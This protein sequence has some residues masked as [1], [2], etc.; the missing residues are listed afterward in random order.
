MI[1]EVFP[2][3][4]ARDAECQWSDPDLFFPEIMTRQVEAT[5]KS[6]CNVHCPVQSECLEFA[7]EMESSLSV[8]YRAGIWVGSRLKSVA[9]LTGSGLGSKP[10]ALGDIPDPLAGLVGGAA[11]HAQGDS[12][13]PVSSR[14]IDGGDGDACVLQ[15]RGV[16]VA[17]GVG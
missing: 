16:G 15:Q 10:S 4:W 8:R 13:G 12:W 9:I 2:G 5:A 17:Q 14:L 11:V 1:G 3:E 6:V 7:L